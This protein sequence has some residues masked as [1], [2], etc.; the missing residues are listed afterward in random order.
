MRARVRGTEL[1]FDVD[2]FALVPD[3]PRMVNR[4]ILFLPH[5]GPGGDHTSPKVLLGVLRDTAQLVVFDNRG[6]GQSAACDCRTHDLE[7]N[8]ADLEGLRDYLGVD[9]MSLLGI[10]YGGMVALGYATRYPERVANLILAATA[11]SYRF[12][13]EAKRI[14]N[15]RGT[16]EQIR[17]AERLFSGNF[18]NSEQLHAYYKTMASL[19]ST[20]CDPKKVEENWKRES[21]NYLQLNKGFGGFLRTFDFTHDLHKITCPTLVMVGTHDWICPPSQAFEIAQ[22][23]PQAQLKVFSQAGHRIAADEP[24]A[25][26]ATIR[27]FLISGTA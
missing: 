25:F 9:R 22:R 2:G 6:S 20:T 12:I 13:T 26:F 11:P 27:R 5:G 1:F 15:E 14:L 16:A 17:I 7:N 3:G 8:I 19:Y 18:E 24:E 10:S 21:R 4:P 23:I